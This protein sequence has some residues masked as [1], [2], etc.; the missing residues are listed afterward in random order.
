MNKEMIGR[1]KEAKE[2]EKKA[3]YALLP[4]S[5]SGHISVIENELKSMLKELA[6]ELVMESM[7]QKESEEKKG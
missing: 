5:A 4:D 3:I 6:M 2:Y 1:L 7:K